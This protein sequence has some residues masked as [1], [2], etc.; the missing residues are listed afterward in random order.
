[1]PPPSLPYD[2]LLNLL[3]HA[4]WR[5]RRHLLTLAWMVMGLL[6]SGWIA[7]SEW[8]SFVVGRALLAQSTERL[9]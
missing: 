3:Q 5:D 9:V 2:T 8:T 4:P 6:S 7:P 1:M